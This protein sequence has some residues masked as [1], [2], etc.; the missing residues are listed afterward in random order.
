MLDARVERNIRDLGRWRLI[1]ILLLIAVPGGLYALFERQARRLDALAEHGAIATATVRTVSSQ[2][3]TTYV[4]YEY[5][6]GGE[7]HSWSVSQDDAPYAVGQAFPVLYLSENPSFSRPT[8]DRA[9]ATAEAVANRSFSGKVVAGAFAFFAVAAFACDS[10][11]RRLRKRGRNEL[12]DPRGQRRRLA[13]TGAMLAPFLVLILYGHG[14]D[15]LQRGE[16]LWSVILGSLLGLSVLGGIAF[17]MMRH[18][19][20]QAAARS[21]RLLKWVAPIAVGV[22]ALRLLLWLLGRQ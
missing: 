17:Y 22:A 21:A 18:G 10:S 19:S 6:V 15:A 7:T 20:A 13:F 5:A 4:S 2:G 3:S 9:R 16:S 14:K 11:L 1:F 8:V 12:D